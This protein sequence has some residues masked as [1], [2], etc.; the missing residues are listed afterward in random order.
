MSKFA[1]RKIVVHHDCSKHIL[2]VLIPGTYV[3]S[4]PK[5]DDFFLEGVT[6]CSIVGK[7][8]CGKSSLVELMFRIINNLG[9]FMLK[10]VDRPAAE[11]IYFVDG[12]EADLH[13]TLNGKDGILKCTHRGVCLS[14]DKNSFEWNLSGDGCIHKVGNKEQDKVNFYPTAIK[15][16]EHFFYTIATN[17]SMQ[18]YISTDYMSEKGYSWLPKRDAN[19]NP[20]NKKEWQKDIMGCWLDSVFHKNDGYMCPI[21]LNP[22]RDEGTIDMIKEARLTTNRLCALL[23]QTRKEDYQII[24]G[25]RL[26]NVKYWFKNDHL[27]SKFDKFHLQKIQDLSFSGKFQLALGKDKSYAK[28]VLDGYGLSI[29]PGM[30]YLEIELLVYLVYKTFSVAKKY[31]QYSHFKRLG[32]INNTFMWDAQEADLKDIRELVERI[33]ADDTHITLK[34]HQTLKV[35]KKISSLEQKDNLDKQ[36]TYDEYQN[37]FGEDEECKTVAERLNILPPPMFLP[38]I[39]LIKEKDYQDIKKLKCSEEEEKRLIDEKSIPLSRLSSGERQFIYMTSTLIYH[40]FNLASVP[41][42]TRLAYR[43]ICMVMDEVEICFHP[44]YQRKFLKNLLNLIK[45]TG[46]NKTFGINIMIVTH[47]PFVLSDI[48]MGN[49]MYLENGKNVTNKKRFETFGS[50]VNDLLAQSFFLENGFM[51]EFAKDRINALINRLTMKKKLSKTECDEATDLIMCIGESIVREQLMMMLVQ[52]KYGN[53]KESARNWLNRIID[54][55]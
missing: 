42:K 49:I 10:D 52:K 25:Y 20:A 2:K 31:P 26:A 19:G 11:Q 29:V 4:D 9:A 41:V 7:N 47:S 1:I 53:D 12:I 55:L 38:Y 48:P 40:A 28:E 37:L 18:A 13:Y 22:Y 54:K 15:V 23:L 21:V 43:N 32:D 3:F 8:G 30:T 46:L 16:A 27:L 50:N 5:L 6:V 17:Y 51:G 33:K 34:I 45:R 24:E 39:Y 35:F 44:E 14:Y 36:M